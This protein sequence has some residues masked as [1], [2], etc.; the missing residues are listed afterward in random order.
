LGVNHRHSLLKNFVKIKEEIVFHVVGN[1][2][3]IRIYASIPAKLRNYFENMFFAAYSTSD[4]VLQKKAVTVPRSM[5]YIHC[6]KNAEIA[7]KDFFVQDGSYIDPMRDLLSIF[8]SVPK[9]SHM[10]MAI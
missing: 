6:N 1:T 7:T 5:H 4:L 2:Y 9:E 3:A 8:S 10:I